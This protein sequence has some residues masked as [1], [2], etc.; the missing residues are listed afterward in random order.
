[1]RDYITDENKAVEPLDYVKFS[2]AVG[3]LHLFATHK[4][5]VL[6]DF[7]PPPKS[8]CAKPTA[9]K[10][11]PVIKKTIVQ[12][13]EYFA[14]R[15]KKFDLPLSMIGTPFQVRVW[16]EL[17]KIPYGE[18]I[19]YGEEARRLGQKKAY[20]AVGTANGRNPLPIV[21]PCH[22]VIATGGALGGYGGG[23]AVKRKL[24]NLEGASYKG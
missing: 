12:L 20:R 21:V 8:V 6:I 24:L 7:A 11:N 16:N 4:A 3:I 17:C 14:G 5:L 19:S 2:C 23:L 22:R 18:T 10:T 1:M 15:R 9:A 13:K